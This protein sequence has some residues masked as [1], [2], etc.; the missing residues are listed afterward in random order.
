[1]PEARAETP[2][3][4]VAGNG[5]VQEARPAAAAAS[6][7][8]GAAG[9]GRVPLVTIAVSSGGHE[10]AGFSRSRKV[11]YHGLLQRGARL[12][13]WPVPGGRVTSLSWDVS[14][15]LW[16]AGSDGVWMLPPRGRPA[17]L[18]LGLPA[19][20]VVSQLRVAPDG[21][22]I[23]MIVHGPQWTGPQLLLAAIG[24]VPRGGVALGSTVP[25]GAEISHPTQLTWYDADNLIVLSR[26]PTGPQLW[27]VPV[28]GGSPTALNAEPGT[29]SITAAG[30]ANPMAA[31]L[32]GDQLA[33]TTSLNGTWAPQKRLVRSPVYPG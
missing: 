13:R 5:A 24:P 29:R 22:R 7:V 33:L 10:V 23:A 4:S 18:G 30:P 17:P 1:M 9:Q 28:N 25:I 6:D 19:G 20:S 12:A 8:P 15:N 16:V 14:G 2:L 3:Y 21:V 26:S 11:V 31:A 32:P 27:E